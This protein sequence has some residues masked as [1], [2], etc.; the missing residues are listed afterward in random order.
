MQPTQTKIEQTQ[1]KKKQFPNW[2][3]FLI[4]ISLVL[5]VFFRFSHLDQ[6]VYWK[7]EAITSLRIS[8]YTWADLIQQVYHGREIGV[9]D[10][11]KY[12]HP[13]PEKGTADTIRSLAT[14]DSQHPPLYYLI[15]RFWAQWFGSSVALIR[16]LSALT[17]LLVFPCIY[18]LC[19]ELFESSRVGWV[20]I[21]LTAVSLFH[22][23][24]AQEAR[25]YTLWTV[26]ILLSS[27]SLLRAMRGFQNRFNWAIYA[28]NA[29]IGLYTF[30]LNIL[31]LIGH[32]IY[33]LAIEN[34]RFTKKTIYYLF[35]SMTAGIVFIPWIVTIINSSTQMQKTTS[36]VVNK[37]LGLSFLVRALVANVSQVFSIK[38]PVGKVLILIIIGYSIYYIIGKTA[39]Q[40]WLFVLILTV[41][42][43][44][45]LILPDLILGGVR[46]A[47]SRYLI[48][49]YLGIQL[50][51]AYLL[52]DQMT[53]MQ[54]KLWQRKLWQ[55][56]TIALITTGIVAG[57][58]YF[59]TEVA[60][61]K[62]ENYNIPVARIVNQAKKPLIISGESSYDDI[63]S[64]LSLSYLLDSKVKLQLVSKQHKPKVA[65]GFSDVFLYTPSPSGVFQNGIEKEQNSKLVP[66]YEDKLFKI[67]NR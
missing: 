56:I 15:A 9:E 48:P 30:P 19:L 35:Y 49:C 17:S 63:G 67:S 6:K 16:S 10:I 24:Y 58:K 37:H 44:I 47:V 12:L 62:D 8:G 33:V 46:S 4:V 2:L 32:G 36:W 3:R 21:A 45:S 22:I 34:F 66:I 51:V 60:S 41:F 57:V 31:V 61:H 52:T 14:E 65:S 27:A 28:T 26:T 53:S 25:E 55:I 5:G 13:N 59:Q 39:K 42:P 40:V 1:I 54:I 50:A 43:L 29:A 18:W 20:T 11:Q 7:D 23:M 38:N 64:L